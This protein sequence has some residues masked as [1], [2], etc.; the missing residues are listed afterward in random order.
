MS[1]DSAKMV[2]TQ[3]AGQICGKYVCLCVVPTTCLSSIMMKK[4]HKQ[5]KI[6]KTKS[7][8]EKI[9]EQKL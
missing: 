3:E 4:R 6:R 8:T 1:R 5:T 2:H 7:K 9:K